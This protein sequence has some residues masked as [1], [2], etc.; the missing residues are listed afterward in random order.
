MTFSGNE[1]RAEEGPDFTPTFKQQLGFFFA[2]GSADEMPTWVRSVPDICRGEAQCR[3]SFL[4]PPTHFLSSVEK[5]NLSIYSSCEEGST[6]APPPNTAQHFALTF[7][8]KVVHQAHVC[9]HI[10]ERCDLPG[11]TEGTCAAPRSGSPV[12]TPKP[13]GGGGKRGR[14]GLFATGRLNET[15]TRTIC[16]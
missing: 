12:G 10:A 15:S 6:K 3:L 16:G 5:E 14:P 7:V 1:G 8:C 9:K 11:E 13:P 4:F 2:S